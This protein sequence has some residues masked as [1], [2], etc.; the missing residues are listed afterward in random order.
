MLVWV[1]TDLVS[2]YVAFEAVLV[3]LFITVG[4]WGAASRVRSAF[5]LF[6][7]TLSGSLLMLM[8]LLTVALNVGSGDF[9]LL[10]TVDLASQRWVWLGL[11][12]AF[13]VKTPMVPFHMWL[14]RAHA[15]APLAASMV[16]AG[17]VLK[18]ATYGY[19]RLCLGLMPVMSQWFS[20]LVQAIGLVS[21][22]YS[23]LATLRQSDMK[24]LIAYSSIGHMAVVV[25]G[26]FSGSLIGITGAMLLSLAHGLVS[27]ALFILTGGVLYDRYHTRV[28][29]YY[30]GLG[31]CM[32]VFTTLFLLATVMNMGQPLSLNWVGEFTS[33]LGL[34]TAAPLVTA[35]ACLVQVLAACYAIWLYVR[36][37][38]GSVSP[39]LS[40]PSFNGVAG[41]L[42]ADV[43]RREYYCLI[44]LLGPA[45]IFG[46]WTTPL[47]QL[48]SPSLSLLAALVPTG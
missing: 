15:D 16:L 36:M 7:F 1:V 26:L 2:F 18:L 9:S 21:L 33:L 42:P 43:T 32:P 12:I 38:S 8:A 47:V 11:F 45:I 22:I 6:M 28:V 10:M 14:P 44:Y 41:S 35:V 25:L 30:R 17:T 34:F 24:A 5:L 3:P 37:T 39:Y 4:V 40:V 27:P 20:P 19:L 29:F 23:S 48:M 46:V 31:L 13:A